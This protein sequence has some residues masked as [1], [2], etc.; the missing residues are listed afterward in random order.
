MEALVNS[1]WAEIG[2]FKHLF[3][4]TQHTL[5]EKATSVLHMALRRYICTAVVGVVLRE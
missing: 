2:M 4:Y 1:E 3:S 5:M